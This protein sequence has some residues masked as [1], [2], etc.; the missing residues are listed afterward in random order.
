MDLEILN[1]ASLIQK[2]NKPSI[3]L[4][5]LIKD[6]PYRIVDGKLTN[7]KFGKVVLLELK[8]DVVFLPKR[9]TETDKPFIKYSKDQRYSLVFRGVGATT[10]NKYQAMLFEIVDS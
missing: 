10:V 3:K 6:W 9:A 1:A 8:T 7:S 5:D 2:E 4:A